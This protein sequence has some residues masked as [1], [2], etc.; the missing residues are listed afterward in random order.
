MQPET[1]SIIRSAM[2]L[3]R[4]ISPSQRDAILECCREIAS[5]DDSSVATTAHASDAVQ[6]EDGK[7][8]T[9]YMTTRQAAAYLKKSYSW[10]CHNMK[11]IPHYRFG[12]GGGHLFK[13]EDLDCWLDEHRRYDPS[14]A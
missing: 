10:I 7:F 13:R 9:Q 4:S 3:D 12:G 5:T 6:N 11:R 2:C 1:Y 8:C 14:A